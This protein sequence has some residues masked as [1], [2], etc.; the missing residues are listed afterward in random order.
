MLIG[1]S[2]SVVSPIYCSL[3]PL[4]CITFVLN[5]IFALHSFEYFNNMKDRSIK[6]LQRSLH[7]VILKSSNRW[8]VNLAFVCNIL[9]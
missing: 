7:F 8:F 4:D 1:Q 6:C 3:Q 9:D 5:V 2:Y